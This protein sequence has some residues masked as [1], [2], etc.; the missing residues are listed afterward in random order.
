M[1]SLGA[2]SV[3][4]RQPETDHV[5]TTHFL[6][7]Q[8]Y[9]GAFSTDSPT[10]ISIQMYTATAGKTYEITSVGRYKIHMSKNTVYALVCSVHRLFFKNCENFNDPD[11]FRFMDQ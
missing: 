11:F 7:R 8:R 2:A 10:Y 3:P 9:Q 1:V 5:H 6:L 4:V